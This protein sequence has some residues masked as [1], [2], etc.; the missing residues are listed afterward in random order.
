MDKMKS[1]SSNGSSRDTFK[2][3]AQLVM[4]QMIILGAIPQHY[5]W[6]PLCMSMA[7]KLWVHCQT[8]KGMYTPEEQSSGG[9]TGK[10]KYVHSVLSPLDHEIVSALEEKRFLVYLYKSF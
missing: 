7:T 10:A 4:L 1:D 8:S 2:K 5:Q 9:V 6:H 3:K